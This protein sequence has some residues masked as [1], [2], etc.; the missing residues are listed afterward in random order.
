MIL[1]SLKKKL[2]KFSLL[3]TLFLLTVLALSIP[4]FLFASKQQTQTQQ[5]AAGVACTAGSSG[6]Y[7]ECT[8]SGSLC[9]ASCGILHSAQVSWT[10]GANGTRQYT[11]GSCGGTCGGGSSN[12]PKT[13]Y[14]NTCVNGTCTRQSS[15]SPQSTTNQCNPPGSS[16]GGST[17][18]TG[19]NNSSGS[20]S[21]TGG[22][23]NICA[24]FPGN[25][26]T[27]GADGNLH[28]CSGNTDTGTISCGGKGCTV[29]NG[30]VDD[31]CNGSGSCGNT[32]SQTCSP[33]NKTGT[34]KTGTCVNGSCQQLGPQI[35]MGPGVQACN[36]QCVNTLND[37][38]NCGSCGHTCNFGEKCINSQCTVPTVIQCDSLDSSDNNGYTVLQG[39]YGGN[40][41]GGHGYCAAW[42]EC[43]QAGTG[44]DHCAAITSQCSG[45]MTCHSQGSC[46]M[47]G[48]VRCGLYNLFGQY[49]GI[50]CPA[51]VPDAPVSSASVIVSPSGLSNDP[52]DKTITG[53]ITIVDN[54]TLKTIA[55]AKDSLIYSPEREAYINGYFNLGEIPAGT[56][57]LI[58]HIDK[59]LDSE[60]ISP[61]G[62]SVLTIAPFSSNATRP[63]TVIPGDIAPAL[64]PDNFI[65]IIDYNHLISCLGKAPIRLCKTSDLNDDGKIDQQD[66]DLLFQNFGTLGFSINT[67]Q[68]N[69]TP[70]PNCNSGQNT[71]Q[72]CALICTKTN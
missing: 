32:G 22:S 24:S 12:T 15:T 36:G 53:I 29:C 61:N 39:T 35:C 45:G 13:Y 9:S 54:K 67:P 46:H 68:F 33:S 23:T 20:K 51:N 44:V 34:C 72:M 59:Y 48:G 58:L 42:Q 31:V 41:T 57:Q 19:G 40:S 49:G 16:C 10:C 17:N 64:H 56:Y 30:N 18:N 65:D 38:K 43:T 11:C 62:N 27:C 25:V 7:T 55:T 50:C 28:Q 26:K 21:N 71:I 37:T 47:V 1:P 60:L 5:S 3:N 52:L 70:D 2:N 14:Y 4:I 69:C 6:S 8:N 66:I 63:I